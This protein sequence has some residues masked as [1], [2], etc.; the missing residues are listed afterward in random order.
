MSPLVL[1]LLTAVAI[2]AIGLAFVPGVAG[3][4]RASKRMKR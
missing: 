1:F 4:G 2:G 3:G